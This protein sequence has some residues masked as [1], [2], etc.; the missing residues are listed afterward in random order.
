MLASRMLSQLGERRVA[1]FTRSRHDT[2]V[3][4]YF[5]W[6][7]LDSILNFIDT[8]YVV[9]GA[10]SGCLCRTRSLIPQRICMFGYLLFVIC[11]PYNYSISSPSHPGLE[12]I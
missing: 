9:H 10:S 6:D 8:G 7:A 11:R 3:L 5:L 2:C 1:S 12:T 4:S